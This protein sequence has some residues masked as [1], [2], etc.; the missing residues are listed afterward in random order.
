LPAHII[1][2]TIFCSCERSRIENFNSIF[3]YSA[4]SYV[5]SCKRT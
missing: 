2:R 4:C 3:E 1:G 5:F